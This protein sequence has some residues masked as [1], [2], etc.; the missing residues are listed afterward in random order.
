MNQYPFPRIASRRAP[1]RP[2]GKPH[3]V[4][5]IERALMSLTSTSTTARDLARLMGGISIGQVYAAMGS[6]RYHGIPVQK[7]RGPRGQSGFALGDIERAEA[8]ASRKNRGRW[9]EPTRGRAVSG[10]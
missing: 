3:T 5:L 1:R 9:K 8:I 4:N 7:V 6:L 10:S 2:P